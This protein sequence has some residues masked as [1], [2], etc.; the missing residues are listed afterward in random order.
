MLSCFHTLPLCKDVFDSVT[1][2]P[3]CIFFSQLHEDADHVAL[4]SIPEQSSFQNI[5]KPQTIIENHPSLAVTTRPS[6]I[7]FYFQ[8]DVCQVYIS[9]PLGNDLDYIDG[10]E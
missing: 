2:R 7:C 8:L 3:M 9:T 10:R 5:S 6:D 4:P 1:P